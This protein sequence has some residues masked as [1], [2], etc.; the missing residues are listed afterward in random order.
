MVNW[1]EF[2]KDNK[3]AITNRNRIIK[4]KHLFDKSP[5]ANLV[6]ACKQQ[7]TE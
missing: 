2:I 5:E 1:K 4:G 6:I 3:Q 7:A